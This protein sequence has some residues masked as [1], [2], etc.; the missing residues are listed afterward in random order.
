MLIDKSELLKA[1][2]EAHNGPPGKARG[3]I[4]EAPGVEAVPLEPLAKWLAKFGCP[5]EINE[6]MCDQAH[7]VERCVGVLTAALFAGS[8]Y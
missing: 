4:E 5:C 6:G 2:D 8:I 1:Y 7:G 3:L